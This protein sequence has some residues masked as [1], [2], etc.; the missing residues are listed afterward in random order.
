MTA[1]FLVVVLTTKPLG[2]PGYVDARVVHACGGRANT[3]IRES[4]GTKLYR[5]ST[6]KCKYT[7][8]A[9]AIVKQPTKRKISVVLTKL[10]MGGAADFARS[11]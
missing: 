2:R 1:R 11:R 8:N 6:G 5:Q 9:K 4:G 10:F 3:R 7:L